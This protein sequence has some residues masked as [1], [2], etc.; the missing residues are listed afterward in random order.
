MGLIL[1]DGGALILVSAECA[2]DFAQSLPLAVNRGP[3]Y[4]IG[5]GESVETPMVTSRV[6]P[7]EAGIQWREESGLTLD[8]RFLRG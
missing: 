6:I 2:R 5:T 7:A 8:P 3:V 1:T 4:V